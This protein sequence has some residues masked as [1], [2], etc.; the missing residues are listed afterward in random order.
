MI[1]I[2]GTGRDI[3]DMLPNRAQGLRGKPSLWNSVLVE[4]GETQPILE[5][6]G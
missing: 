2:L 4:N 6:L 3:K 1:D 5:V